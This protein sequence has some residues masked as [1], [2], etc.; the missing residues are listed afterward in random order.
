MLEECVCPCC[1]KLLL[2]PRFWRHM[3]RLEGIRQG[4]GFP[5]TINSGCRCAEHNASIGGADNSEHLR[6]ATDVRPEWPDGKDGDNEYFLRLD[7][8]YNEAILIGFT[9][10]KKYSTWVHMDLREGPKWIVPELRNYTS[11]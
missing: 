1:N 3:V 11:H 2:I 9:G 8:M 4:L 6:F 5:M 10:V 7:A